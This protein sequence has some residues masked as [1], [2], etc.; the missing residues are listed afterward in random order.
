MGRRTDVPAKVRDP[1]RLRA[2]SR[3]FGAVRTRR[4]QVPCSDMRHWRTWAL[5][6]VVLWIAVVTVWAVRPLDATVITGHTAD[7]SD[8]TA[9]VEC[10]SPLSG[11]TSPTSALP[12]LGSGEAFGDAP[13]HDAVSSGRAIYVIDVVCGVA[14]LI[15]LLASRGRFDE[16]SDPTV[17]D[18]TTARA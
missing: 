10:D 2:G 8:K 4:P 9:T 5:V 3:P 13:C 7:G 1:E 6:V 17:A 16:R 11:N 12:A 18:A 15:L 14:L